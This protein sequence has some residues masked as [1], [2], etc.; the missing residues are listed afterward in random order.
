MNELTAALDRV[1]ENIAAHT[2]AL[3]GDVAL[4]A[5]RQRTVTQIAAGAALIALVFLVL[6]FVLLVQL[7]HLQHAG[8]SVGR[9]IADCTTPGGSCYQRNQAQTGKAVGSINQVTIIVGRCAKTTSTDEAMTGCIDKALAANGLPPV[10][11]K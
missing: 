11:V 1:S 7:G 5:R 3:R 4:F 8:R 9:Q 2:D 10:T 6:I